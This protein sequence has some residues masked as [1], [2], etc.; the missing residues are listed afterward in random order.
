MNKKALMAAAV[1][2]LAAVVVFS[3]T[4]RPDRTDQI[5]AL[6]H[7]IEALEDRIAELTS[8]PAAADPAAHPTERQE[9]PVERTLADAAAQPPPE[10]I[11][12]LVMAR[13]QHVERAVAETDRTLSTTIEERVEEAVDEKISKL[14]LKQNLKPPLADFAEVL[15]LDE[16]QQGA[17]EDVIWLGQDS[18]RAILET[19]TADGSV[20]VDGLVEALAYGKVGHP[21]AGRIFMEWVGQ[22]MNTQIP[23]SD[24]TYGWRI[25]AAKKDVRE[26]LR[27]ELTEEQYAEFERWNVDPTEVQEIQDSPWTDIGERI[28]QR[29][30]ELTD[31][32]A[33]ANP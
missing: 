27:R 25:E 8:G 20:L 10:T 4:L 23:G 5:E 15:E 6:E 18:V 7:R 2:V 11:A 16:S 32:A 28:E 19:P 12:P 9:D 30:L 13:L 17:V 24:D 31:P 14:E 29:A 3:R 21:E 1:G 22:V 33:A 26:A